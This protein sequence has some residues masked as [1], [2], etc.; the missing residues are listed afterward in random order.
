MV[1]DAGIIT[2]IGNDFSYKMDSTTGKLIRSE[3]K[4]GGPKPANA[5]SKLPRLSVSKVNS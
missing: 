1:D 2:C 3:S 5:N 4:S